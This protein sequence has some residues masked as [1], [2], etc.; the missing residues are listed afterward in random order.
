LIPAAPP[1]TT[2]TAPVEKAAP[3][4]DTVN[5]AAPGSQPPAQIGPVDGKA[6][7]PAFDSGDESSSKHKKKK[8]LARLNPF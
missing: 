5:E 6:P 7:K 1:N 3:A 8:G 4:P 2:V